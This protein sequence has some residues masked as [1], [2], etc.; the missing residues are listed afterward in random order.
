M[1][2][3]DDD[4]Y[5]I[6]AGGDDGN[7]AVPSPWEWMDMLKGGSAENTLLHTE[8]AEEEPSL[9]TNPA[10]EATYEYA[11]QEVAEE[12]DDVDDDNRRIIKRWDYW[13]KSQAIK[14]L[15][16]ADLPHDDAARPATPTNLEWDGT[17]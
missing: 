5:S 2:N 12:V 1:D 6:S 7:D 16:T 4:I 9:A 15:K 11:S 10:P 14:P 3:I 8:W 13:Q 17:Y